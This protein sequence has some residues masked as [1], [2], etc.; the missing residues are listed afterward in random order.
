M[1]SAV[2]LLGALHGAPP[3]L[4]GS[5]DA[6]VRQSP[7][8]AR[9]AVHLLLPEWAVWPFAAQE[10]N[11]R[12][13]FAERPLHVPWAPSHIHKRE[14][15]SDLAWLGGCRSGYHRRRTPCTKHCGAARA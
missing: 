2:G 12:H 14:A 8:G 1:G 7:G 10:L 6:L 11:T 4:V 5:D 9:G 15:H 3:S 13:P